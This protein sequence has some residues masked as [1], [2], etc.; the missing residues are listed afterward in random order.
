MQELSPTLLVTQASNSATSL[1]RLV[2][3][4]SP[5]YTFCRTD[6]I[7]KCTYSRK[8]DSYTIIVLLDNHDNYF[9]SLDLKG[10]T[11]TLSRGYKTSEGDEYSDTPPMKVVDMQFISSPGNLFCYLVMVS[12]LDLMAGEP[13]TDNYDPTYIGSY[14]LEWAVM[15]QANAGA[16]SITLNRMYASTG[17]SEITTGTK[18]TIA[19]DG[20]VY[21]VSAVC[22]VNNFTRWTAASNHTKYPDFTP[23]D[24]VIPTEGNENG[25]CYLCILP[26]YPTIGTTAALD[27]N[28]DPVEPDWPEALVP[29]E[30]GVDNIVVDND[31]TWQNFGAVVTLAFTPTLAQTATV[32]SVVTLYSIGSVATLKDHIDSICAATMTGFTQYTPITTSWD[33]ED[34]LIDVLIPKDAFKI[35]KNSSTRKE[36][37]DFLIRWTKMVYR[38]GDD[39]KLHFFSP[40]VSGTDYDYTYAISGDHPFLAKSYQNSIVRPNSIAVSDTENTYTGGA[41]DPSY[42]TILYWRNYI[43]PII[44]NAQ[45]NL[46]AQAIIQRSQVNCQGGSTRVPIMNVGQELWDYIQVTDDREGGV[47]RTCNI[48]KIVETWDSTTKT[49]R[50]DMLISTGGG[51]DIPSGNAIAGAKDAVQEAINTSSQQVSSYTTDLISQISIN[52]LDLIDELRLQIQDLAKQ[53]HDITG[54][55]DPKAATNLELEKL[56]V[57]KEAIVPAPVEDNHAVTKLYCDKN[58]G[59]VL[60]P[61]DTVEDETTFAIS[62]DEGTSVEYSRGDHTHGTLAQEYGYRTIEF[63]LNGLNALT[64]DD[65]SYARIPAWMDGWS[66]VSVAGMCK[67]ASTDGDITLTLKNGATPMLITNIT[68]EEGE[69]DSLTA[70]VQPD[71]DSNYEQ[72]AEGDHLEAS[73]VAAGTEVTHCVIEATFSHS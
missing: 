43:F 29:G 68:I 58:K 25:R 49:S 9:T 57:T 7:K 36:R 46:V 5:S 66:L 42:S 44:S 27:E 18:F 15:T 14:D 28:G 67:E 30:S 72:V 48:Q 47:A 73:C 52:T 61:S 3:T 37:I 23:L 2:L 34:S 71:I 39:G 22:P 53:F 64:T 56:T 70:T 63:P 21:T 35:Y 41:T 62:P 59:E 19:G 32:S 55:A 45:G 10:Y 60:I 20:T 31:I 51:S 12:Q 11:A 4:G 69:T 17:T 65:K 1:T 24:I 13:A 26:E 33:S 38:L 50:F 40:K 16:S 8:P 54:V 6:R